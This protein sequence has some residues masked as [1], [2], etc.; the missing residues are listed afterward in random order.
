MEAAFPKMKT[1]EI[2]VKILSNTLK[3]LKR[4]GEKIIHPLSEHLPQ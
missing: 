4:F 3:T 2:F 1:E